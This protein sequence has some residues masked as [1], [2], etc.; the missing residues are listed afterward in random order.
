MTLPQV[1][2]MYNGDHARKETLVEYG[3]RLPSALDNR[4]LI[5]TEFQ[6][7]IK[8]AIYV[9]ATPGPYELEHS[10]EPAEQVIRP[11]GLLDPE[12]EVRPSAGQIDDLMNEI[13]DRITKQQRTLVTTLT[14]KWPRI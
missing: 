13:E 9:S 5:F 14:K 3:F 2:G 8:N 12:V 1:R 6:D 10:P 4:P 7:H 11:T